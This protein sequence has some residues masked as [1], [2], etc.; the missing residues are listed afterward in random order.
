[1]YFNGVIL[2]SPT[3]LGLDRSGPVAKTNYLPY[4]AA[5]SWYHKVLPAA[6]QAKDLDEILY[7]VEKY[8][9]EI[10][11]PA[12]AKV[13]S[14]DKEERKSIAKKMYYYSGVK[15]EVFL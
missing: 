3:G 9:L 2:V 6:L 12:I 8:T 4:F 1:M 15:E 14:L 11:L 5:T 13:G 10:L 7:E